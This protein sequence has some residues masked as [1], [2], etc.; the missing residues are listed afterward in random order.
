MIIQ[1][2]LIQINGMDLKALGL[3]STTMVSAEYPIQSIILYPLPSLHVQLSIKMYI[4]NFAIVTRYWRSFLLDV[5][6]YSFIKFQQIII[7]YTLHSK[8]FTANP[9][10]ASQC[11]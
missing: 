1:N 5:P 6:I 10:T 9:F 3:I 11:G 8:T 4:D 2:A 7:A